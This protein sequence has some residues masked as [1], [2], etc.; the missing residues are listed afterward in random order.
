MRVE[1]DQVFTRIGEGAGEENHQ[2]LIYQ[3]S[4]WRVELAECCRSRW[5][6]DADN[7]LQETRESSAGDAHDPDRATAR[8]CGYRSDGV[9]GTSHSGAIAGVPTYPA[10]FSIWRVM[11]HCWEIDNTLFTNQ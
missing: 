4:V 1:F 6:Q 8:R 11:Y 10:A 2:P 7:G 5:R 3:A 9:G